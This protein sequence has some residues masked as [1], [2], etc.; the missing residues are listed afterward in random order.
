[1]STDRFIYVKSDESDDYFAENSTYK[2]RVHLK[3][4][5]Y[6]YNKWKVGLVQIHTTEK[7]KS[8]TKADEGLYIF[9]DLCKETIVYGQERPF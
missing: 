6:L 9:T 3:L 5:L 8:A 2:F 4:P 1:M 7:G